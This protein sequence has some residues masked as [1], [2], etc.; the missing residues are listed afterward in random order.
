MIRQYHQLNGYE[1]EQTPGDSGRQ[2]S[3]ACFSLWGGK[4]WDM[5]WQCNINKIE[6]NVLPMRFV[7][8]LVAQ[9][10]K[11]LPAIQETTVQSLGQE[12]PLEKGMV[13]HS[14]ILAWRIPR[15]EETGKLVRGV[16]KT[17]WWSLWSHKELDT[18]ERLNTHTPMKS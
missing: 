2:R 12:N 16:T 6:A 11:N 4:E 13:T 3:L 8:S 17:P 5:T 14:S 18:T 1:F 9:V 15:T 10:I 7:A